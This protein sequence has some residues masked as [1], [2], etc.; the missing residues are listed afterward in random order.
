MEGE[1]T[2]TLLWNELNRHGYAF[3]NSVIKTAGE[4]YEAKKSPWIFRVAEFPVDV[5]DRNTHIDLVLENHDKKL[6]LIGECK[7]VNPALSNWCFARSQFLRRNR[8]TPKLI[9]QNAWQN[10][11]YAQGI[12]TG[13]G[14]ANSDR[15]YTLGR[16]TKNP[17]KKGDP[18]SS[19]K[20]DSINEASCQ[21]SLGVNGMIQF[22][23]KRPKLLTNR[24]KI[25]LIPAIFTTAQIFTSPV[26]LGSA[27]MNTG[28]LEGAVK[29]EATP[30]IWLQHNLSSGLTH[31][32]TLLPEPRN[33]ES[34]LEQEFCR[35]V[36]IVSPE[37]IESFLGSDLWLEYDR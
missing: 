21:V 5:R 30:W 9:F 23:A 13:T 37:G 12:L 26:D 17:K 22:Y 32:Q 20:E 33:I 19:P 31:S 1:E 7:R 4:L 36:A 34:V 18:Q 29:L 15:V 28:E 3:Q 16:E 27:N 24:G 6:L 10:P 8:E 2:N 35:S 11:N 14:T 25:H